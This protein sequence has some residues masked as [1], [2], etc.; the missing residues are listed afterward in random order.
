MRAATENTRAA[1]PFDAIPHAVPSRTAGHARNVVF[2][3]CDPQ[4]VLPPIAHT[5]TL[6]DARI[7]GELDGAAYRVDAVFGFEAPEHCPGLPEDVLHPE[8]SS[9]SEE[10]YRTRY[11]ELASRYAGNFRKLADERP[12]ELV[13]AGPRLGGVRT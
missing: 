12:L 13:A 5:R 1:C 10:E 11:R 6:L 4:G 9:P 7:E 8:R 3:A 2:L